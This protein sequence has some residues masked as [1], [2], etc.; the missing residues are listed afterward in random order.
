MKSR[1]KKQ[2]AGP[3]DKQRERGRSYVWGQVSNAA[4][5][6]RTVRLSMPEGYTLTAITSLN[7]VRKVLSGNAPAGFRTP[8]M[9][10]GPDLILEVEGAKREELGR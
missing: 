2:P 7:I 6:E 3:D 4:G 10:Y 9:A 8:A 5:E 1:I